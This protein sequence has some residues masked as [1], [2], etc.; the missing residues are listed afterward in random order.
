M[1]VRRSGDGPGA[2]RIAGRPAVF[3]IKL[4][5]VHHNGSFCLIYRR[6]RCGHGKRAGGTGAGTDVAGGRIGLFCAVQYCCDCN[7]DNDKDK[8][9]H[10]KCIF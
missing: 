10:E 2:Q 1:Y 6:N 8:R 4:Q 3:V 5:V 9:T 7:G